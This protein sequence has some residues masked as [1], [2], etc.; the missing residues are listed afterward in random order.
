MIDPPRPPSMIFCAPA[1]TVFQ[2]PVT[3]MS[4]TSRNS[5][6]VISSHACGAATP[7]VGD[8]DVEPAQ[9]GDA[10]VDGLAQPVEVAGVDDRRRG[11]GGPVASTRRTVSSRSSGV[12]GVV[13]HARRQLAGDVDGDDV[14]A[15]VGHP[16]GVRAALAPRRSGD[17]CHL[18]GE[19]PAHL[20]CLLRRL[21]Q[22]RSDDQPLDLAGAL[23]QAQQAHVAVDALDR[24]PRAC[25]RCRRGSAP[26]D[27]RPCRPFRCRTAW[28]PTARSC[29]PR[30]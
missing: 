2:V 15:L 7:G 25:S 16:D 29:G 30:R 12:A 1:I 19:P 10:V 27:R 20:R 9:C 26:R 13:G 17:E 11:S 8:D 3:L 28:P 21:D 14:G 22:I 6:G 18:A 4:M 23:V 5:S 24:Q